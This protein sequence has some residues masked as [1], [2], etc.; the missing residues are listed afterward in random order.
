MKTDATKQYPYLFSIVSAVWGAEDYLEEFAE[1]IFTQS[2]GFEAHVQLILVDDGSPDRSG[3]ICDRLA[4]RY[5]ENVTVLHQANSGVSSARNAGLAHVKGKYVNF[6]DPDDLLSPNTLELVYAFFEEHAGDVDVV[7]IP[8]M[9]FGSTTG[10]HLLNNKFSKGTRV[11]YLQKECNVMQLS[12]ASAFFA[13]EALPER[14]F[15]TELAI[16]EDAELILQML[17][18][19]PYL[20][21]VAEGE[22]RYRRHDASALSNSTGK[23]EWYLPSLRC[24]SMAVMDAAEE[25]YGYVPRF[26]Q[27]VVAYDLQWKVKQPERPAVLSEEEFLA[28]RRLLK[29]C[30]NRLDEKVIMNQRS[31]SLHLKLALLSERAWKAPFLQ[32]TKSNLYFGPDHRV[33]HAISRNAVEWNFLSMHAESVTLSCRQLFS[34]VAPAPET[35]LLEVNGTELL[36][37]ELSFADH[38]KSMG[39]V[40]SRYQIATFT[41]PKELLKKEKTTLRLHTRI[42]EADI[43]METVRSGTWFPVTTRVPMAYY[44]EDGLMFVFEKGQLCLLPADRRAVRRREKAYR[45]ALWQSGELGAK[46]AALARVMLG[47]YRA[48]HKKPVWILSD[49]LIK[50][51]DNGEAFFRYLKSID[52]KGAKYYY[53]I[54]RGADFDA[55]KPLGNVIDRASWKYKFLFSAADKVISSHADD[56]VVNPFDTYSHLYQDLLRTKD[57]IFL[58]HGVT[59]DDISGWLNKYSKNIRGFICAAKPEY[60]SILQTPSY[61][62]TPREAWLTGF[63]RFDRLYRD[64]KKYITIMPT[65]RRYLMVGMDQTTGVWQESAGFCESEYFRFYNGLI[66]H[67]RLLAA[68]KEHG[69]TVCYMPHPTVI[70]KMELFDHHPEVKFFSLQDAYRDVYA[71]SNLVLTDYSSAVFDFAYLRKPVVYAHFDSKTFFEGGHLYEKGYFDYERDGFGEVTYDLESTV[72]MLIDYMKNGCALKPMYRERI[73]NF[74][75]F[76]DKDNCKRILE[77]LL[78]TDQEQ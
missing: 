39:T 70:T 25:H 40:I 30:L 7:S 41:L 68:A 54:N 1:S 8:I 66:N 67:P 73:D 78:E 43:L 50:S 75:A 6:C 63:A 42:G 19:K 55:L 11:I 28:Y 51:G 45:R 65:W 29:D 26:V 13:A 14:G 17:I 57:F 24:F 59:K 36:P 48:T 32:A 34:T 23:K 16:A 77:K 72:D 52:F 44:A 33:Y 9:M 2:I 69:Y 71:Q 35:M 3:E 21:V 56:F 22:Y 47:L 15:R 38:Q 27:N 20:G 12:S 60:D 5:P 58:Q 10:P 62:Y 31:I 37:T 76:S 53:A 64:E 18:R 46:K 61:F 4:A 74:F 49:R